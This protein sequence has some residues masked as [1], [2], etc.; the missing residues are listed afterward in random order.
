MLAPPIQ[1]GPRGTRPYVPLTP[2]TPHHPAGRRI[3]PPMS[4]PVARGTSPAARAAPAPP[5][6][7]PGVRSRSHGL[8]V[9]PWRIELVKKS[10]PISGEAVSPTGTAPAARRRVDI[11]DVAGAT[12]SLKAVLADVAGQPSTHSSSLM[13]SGTPA[14]GPGS[15]PAATCRSTSAATC[16]A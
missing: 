6:D 3:D 15:V 13:P 2:T 9:A 14:K 16:R 12:R 1:P 11:V 4:L 8:R 10:S 7:P 5:L